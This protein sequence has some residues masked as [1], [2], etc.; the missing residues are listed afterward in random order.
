MRKIIEEDFPPSAKR[1]S[2][3]LFGLSELPLLHAKLER[4]CR[5]YVVNSRQRPYFPNH[6]LLEINN[7]MK[8]KYVQLASY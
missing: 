2:S 6:L 8:K 5:R 4:N 7:K 3:L 1:F